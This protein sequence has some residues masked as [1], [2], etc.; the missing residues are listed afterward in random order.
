MIEASSPMLAAIEGNAHGA[1]G[2]KPTGTTLDV[3]LDASTPARVHMRWKLYS[4]LTL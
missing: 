2:A 1:A 3:H 4:R